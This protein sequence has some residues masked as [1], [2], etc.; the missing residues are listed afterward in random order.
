MQA[1]SGSPVTAVE[2]IEPEEVLEADVADPGEVA[3]V[4]K[5]QAE[6]KAGKY[7]SVKAK[8]FKPAETVEE[9]EEETSWID[10]E[11]VDDA[12]SPVPGERYVVKLSDGCEARGTLDANGYAHI[13]KI[14]PGNCDVSF[15]KLDA[16]AWEKA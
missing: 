12:G 10:I 16:A 4:K 9:A 11:L 2:P 1:K 13:D 14:P 5:K 15:P 8:P 7:G 6:K 3:K